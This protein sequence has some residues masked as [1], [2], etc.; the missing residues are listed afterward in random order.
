MQDDGALEAFTVCAEG[1]C[2]HSSLLS[3]HIPFYVSTG[4]PRKAIKAIIDILREP[5]SGMILKECFRVVSHSPL[6]HS[7]AHVMIPNVT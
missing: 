5:R 1:P 3:Y 2:M 4:L 7:V 6:P